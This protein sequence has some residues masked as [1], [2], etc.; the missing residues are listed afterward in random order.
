MRSILKPTFAALVVP[1]TLALGLAGCQAPPP[2]TAPAPAPAPVAQ[3]AAPAP[4]DASVAAPAVAPADSPPS[5]APATEAP[6]DTPMTVQE[7]QQRLVALG[8]RPGPVDGKSGPKTREA[9]RLFQKDSGLKV[10]GS[11]DPE[12]IRQ[13]RASPTRP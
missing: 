5:P 11:L 13:L 12:T 3:P 9:L 8:Y 7:A 1:A 6:A 4:A 2:A 10:T